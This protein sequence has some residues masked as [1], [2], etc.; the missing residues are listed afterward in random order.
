MNR[1]QQIIDIY[2]K[3]GSNDYIGENMTQTEHA[4]QCAY[5]AKYY[6]Y[7]NYLIIAALLHDIGHIIP[8][9]TLSSADKM[10]NLGILRHENKGSLF[11]S[12]LGYNDK[13]CNLVLNHV[14][15]KRY[16]CTIDNK[17]I[18]KLSE[19][20]KKIMEYQGN[21]MTLEEIIEFKK[22]IYFED[23]IKL[24]NLDDMGKQ[25]NNINYGKIEDYYNLLL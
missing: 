25:I 13:I 16:L 15:T 6:N 23:C 20:S 22:N 4:L 11:L 24:R 18:N 8:Y 1:S 12:K 17:Y 10:N 9:D 3:F 7:D 19:A 14:N 5:Y 21:L 2:N